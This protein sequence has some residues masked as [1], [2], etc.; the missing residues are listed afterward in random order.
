[1]SSHRFLYKPRRDS[2]DAPVDHDHCRVSVSDGRGHVRQCSRQARTFESVKGHASR[3]GF[4]AQH[5]QPAT[6]RR[7]LERQEHHA[8]QRRVERCRSAHSLLACSA[9]NVIR[10]LDKPAAIRLGALDLWE[11]I[12]AHEEERWKTRAHEEEDT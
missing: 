11:K 10:L 9:Y 3:L 1:M 8:A 12:R 5:S 7:E 4:C 2:L 6:D